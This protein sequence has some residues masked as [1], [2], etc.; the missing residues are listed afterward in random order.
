M[1]K[2]KKKSSEKEQKDY[3]KAVKKFEKKS[4]KEAEKHYQPHKILKKAL[5]PPSYRNSKGRLSIDKSIMHLLAKLHTR[6]LTAVMKV[7]THIGDGYFWGLICVLLFFVNLGA[8]LAVTFAQLIEIIFQKILKFIF[9]RER[10]YVKHADISN[11][12]I[13]PDRF[14][15][16]SGHTAA[17]MAMAVSFAAVFP[18]FFIPFLIL[19]CLIAF[20]R[21]YLGLHYPS[22]VAVGVMLGIASAKLAV[23]IVGLM[24]LS[25]LI[26]A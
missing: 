14:S 11:L 22:D 20:S 1:G 23:W 25:A 9:L 6:P 5:V 2:K 13:P 10:P 7:I 15:F 12:I 26:G 18:A 17:S 24:G 4:E 16:P 21:M 19:A 3:R 8:A